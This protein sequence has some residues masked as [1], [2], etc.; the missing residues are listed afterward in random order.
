MD[1]EQRRSGAAAN[2]GS[3]VMADTDTHT[4]MDEAGKEASRAAHKAG[5]AVK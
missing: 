2:D 1:A 5:D 4:S 3:M